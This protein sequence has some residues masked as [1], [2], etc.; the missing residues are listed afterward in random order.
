MAKV[1]NI[2]S[3]KVARLENTV[4]HNLRSKI[5][6]VSFF[7]L[8]SLPQ[9]DSNTVLRKV[10]LFLGPSHTNAFSEVFVFIWA[11]TKQNIFIH[12]SVFVPFAP[13]HTK[14][15]ESDENNWDLGLRMC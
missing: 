13:I 8:V 11:Q 10:A 2:V 15:L 1:G 9:T 12:I 14:T 7:T 4:F 6:F 5:V 3:S